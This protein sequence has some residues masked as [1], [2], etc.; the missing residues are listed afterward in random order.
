MWRRQVDSSVHGGHSGPGRR[1]DQSARPGRTPS[2]TG[3]LNAA[4]VQALQGSAGN[5]AVGHMLAAGSAQG[6]FPVQ[7]MYHGGHGGQGSGGYAPAPAPQ[8]MTPAQVTGQISALVNAPPMLNY[9]ALR[10]GRAHEQFWMRFPRDMAG[11]EAEQTLSET[12]TLLFDS[13]KGAQERA[14]AAEPDQAAEDSDNREVQGM[15]I[16]D[17]LVFATNFNSSIDTLVDEGEQEFGEGPT[18]QELLTI[19]QSDAG[20]TQNLRP[21]EAENLRDKLESYRRKNRAI[22]MKQRGAGEQGRGYDAT[23]MALRRKLKAPVIVANVEDGDLREMLT[24]KDF[25][26]RVILL[27]FGAL[28]PRKNKQTGRKT[29]EKS[30]HAEQKLLLALGYAGISPHQDVSGPLAIMGKYRPCMGCAAALK[31]YQERMG[32]RGLSFDENYGHY[33]QTSVNNLAEHHRHIMDAHYLE[34]I[35]QMVRED[36]TST[37]ALRHEAAPAGSEFRRGGPTIRVPGRYASRQADVTPPASDAEFEGD[38]YVR[39][40]R[41]KMGQAYELET[42]HLGIGRGSQSHPV[43][44]RLDEL[45]ENQ[46][47]ELH[48]LWNGSA[49]HPPTNESRQRALELAYHYSRKRRITLSILGAAIGLHE[50]RLGTYL[51]KYANE[52]HWEHMPSRSNKLPSQPRERDRHRGDPSKQFTKG[53]QLDDRGRR[54]IDETLAGLRGDPWVAEWER[55]RGYEESGRLDRASHTLNPTKAPSELLLTLARLRRDGYDVPQMSRYLYTGDNGDNLRKAISR[56]GKSLLEQSESAGDTAMG[57]M[58]PAASSAGSSRRRAAPPS[59]RQSTTHSRR[60]QS[61]SSRPER[62]ES[63]AM[64]AGRQ[65]R[66]PEF[67][68]F[69]LR[70]DPNGQPYY[71]EEETGGIY[72]YL[73]GRMVRVRQASPVDTEMSGGYR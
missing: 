58:A 45:T 54:A 27:R 63:S 31:Y 21:H 67:E 36:V 15:L 10:Q 28:D 16:N 12:S 5:T 23:A 38:E 48:E 46:A 29:R 26:G 34:Y 4:Y 72:V 19:Q 62:G 11:Q 57:G 30:V 66:H 35:R 24:S 71:I 53:G 49:A 47:A 14:R 20:R 22:A 51:T 32:F 69:E 55:F 52:G 40:P 42:A 60:R 9:G 50:K 37:P 7:R 59:G 18:L 68:G 61:V 1:T 39:N 25:A 3:G 43:G 33:F 44:R 13:M 6:S 64:G 2:P 17:R 56:K 41:R 73:D 8:Q 70:I 65:P